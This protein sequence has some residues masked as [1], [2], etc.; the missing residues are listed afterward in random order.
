MVEFSDSVPTRLS[1]TVNFPEL[2]EIMRKAQLFLLAPW[3]L[4]L[5][6]SSLASGDAFPHWPSGATAVFFS[7]FRDYPPVGNARISL[8]DCDFSI[9]FDEHPHLRLLKPHKS[10]FSFRFSLPQAPKAAYLEA[11]HLASAGAGGKSVSPV[12]IFVNGKAVAENWNVEKT[13]FCETRWSLGKKLRAGWNEIVWRA[14]ALQTHYWLRRVAVYVHFDRP[15]HVSL[16]VPEV[17][18]ELFWE[19]RFTQCSYNALA[20]V[21]DKFYGIEPWQSDR[22]SYEKRTFVGALNKFKLGGYF[23]WAPWTSYMVQAGTIVWNGHPVTDLKAERFSL[24]TKKVPEIQGNQAVVHYGPGEKARLEKKLKACLKKGPVII[25]TPY[26]AA[27]DR[28]RNAWHHV[29]H[30]DPRTDTVRF[31]PNMTHSV[32]VNLEGDAIKVYDNSWPNGIWIVEPGTIVA[33]TCAM[34]ASVRLDRGGGKTLLGKGFR[35]IENDEYNVVFWRE[36]KKRGRLRA[37]P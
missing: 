36:K 34:V 3:A 24:R 21:L 33:T 26:A 29:K 35:G 2:E 28:G 30:I 22:K 27:L 31:H 23:G 4:F 6:G 8:Q 19:G 9:L 18:N 10:R 32:V 15:V 17:E 13:S 7:D 14:G 12:S 37:S 16:Q 5:F 20:T 11:V 1:K 25:W